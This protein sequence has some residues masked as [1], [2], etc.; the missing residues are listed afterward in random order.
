MVVSSNNKVRDGQQLLIKFLSQAAENLL[1]EVELKNK[2][3][4]GG[5]MYRD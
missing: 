5:P 4:K 2:K 3:N 1:T